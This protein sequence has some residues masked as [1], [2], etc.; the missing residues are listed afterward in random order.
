MCVRCLVDTLRFNLIMT[1]VL[2]K[3]RGNTDRCSEQDGRRD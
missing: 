2:A 1:G 3:R